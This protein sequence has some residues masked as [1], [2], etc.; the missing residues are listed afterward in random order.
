[1]LNI[2]RKSAYIAGYV[3]SYANLPCGW[4]HSNDAFHMVL[5]HNAE[6]IG[7]NEVY[8]FVNVLLTN[9]WSALR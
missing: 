3:F 4:I 9:A 2:N 5:C 8:W 6:C 1:M 7:K